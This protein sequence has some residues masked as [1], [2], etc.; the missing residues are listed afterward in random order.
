[1]AA[2]NEARIVP[3][4]PL[5]LYRHVPWRPVVV[6]ALSLVI[7]VR[8]KTRYDEHQIY[9]RIYQAYIVCNHPDVRGPDDLKF[10]V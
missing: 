1:M 9:P 4:A 10:H 2:T 3:R 6:G 5:A 8:D 7:V